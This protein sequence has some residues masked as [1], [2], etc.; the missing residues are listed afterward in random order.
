MPKYI[1]SN[2]HLRLH[3]PPPGQ[4]YQEPE[5]LDFTHREVRTFT[6]G[7]VEEVACGFDIDGIEL[8]FRDTAYFPRTTLPN[9]HTS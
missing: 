8:C 7:I 1:E 4:N 6:Y 9:A 2:P 3:D 5:A